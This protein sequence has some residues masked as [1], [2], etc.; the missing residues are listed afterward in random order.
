MSSHRGSSMGRR[1]FVTRLPVVAAAA[2][3]VTLSACAGLNYATGR[4]FEDRVA[5]G[6]DA[7]STHDYV[8]VETTRWDRPLY[9]RK[10][11]AG[12]YTAVLAECTHRRCQPEPVGD[13]LVC[14][15]HG[16]EF[17]HD[18]EVL[19][20]PADRPL[21]RFEIEVGADQLTVRIPGRVG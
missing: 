3:S 21:P 14:P 11:A 15:C 6:L 18:G 7:F 12:G 16:S 9:V 19:E 8:F 2:Q 10:Q 17:A 13:R 5:V 4:D 20:G 1:S